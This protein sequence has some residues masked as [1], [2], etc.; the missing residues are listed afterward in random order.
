MIAFTNIFSIKS[1][2]LVSGSPNRNITWQVPQSLLRSSKAPLQRFHLRELL[3]MWK[4]FYFSNFIAGLGSAMIKI[5]G[6]LSQFNKKSGLHW[7]KTSQSGKLFYSGQLKCSWVS[8]PRGR[9]P[10]FSGIQDKRR[11]QQNTCESNFQ[12]QESSNHSTSWFNPRG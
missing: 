5:L 7:W 1:L 6:L 8:H 11:L 3:S 12:V 2:V 10:Y 4:T 9:Y